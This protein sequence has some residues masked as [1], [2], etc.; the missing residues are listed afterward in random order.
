P[1]RIEKIDELMFTAGLFNKFIRKETKKIE[2]SDILPAHEWD[3]VSYLARQSPKQGLVV[4]NEDTAMNPFTWEAAQYAAGACCQ[5]VSGVMDGEFS[6]AFCEVRPPGHHAYRNHSGGFC[7]LNNIAIAT[8]Y[9]IGHY[10]LKRVAVCDFDVHH[11]D[12]TSNILGG[13]NDVL[14]LDCFQENLY[15]YA[16]MHHTPK[17][18]VYS[19]LPEGADSK[20][21]RGVIDEV[22][23]PK[24]MEFAPELILVSAGF[25]GHRDEEQA[26]LLMIEQDYAFIG[27]RLIQ[28]SESI[29]CCR[30]VI[31]ILEGGYNTCSLARSCVSFLLQFTAEKA[32]ETSEE[33]DN[34]EM[35]YC[36][37]SENFHEVANSA[38]LS[39]STQKLSAKS[40]Q[41]SS[42]K[43]Y[44]F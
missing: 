38:D 28:L 41:S 25:D 30:G 8:L 35:D 11:G 10:G 29:A 34:S 4:L 21:L 24:L 15:P 32:E 42:G 43:Q 39:N 19:A 40:A 18:A 27:R 13:R 2:F 26:Q 7:F 9:A 44:L 23:V 16:H 14:I 1:E 17:N 3:Y 12:G 31:A 22:W 36:Q 6:Q 5:A 37:Q 20:D 33:S